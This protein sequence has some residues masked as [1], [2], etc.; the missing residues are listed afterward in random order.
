MFEE[1]LDSPE[2]ALKA[3]QNALGLNPSRLSLI[4]HVVEYC[5]KEGASEQL[6]AGLE[7]LVL[8]AESAEEEEGLTALV[9]NARAREFTSSDGVGDPTFE[10]GVQE[11]VWSDWRLLER[12]VDEGAEV[13]LI[14][15]SL[16][17]GLGAIEG[18]DEE[19][20]AAFLYL[21]DL[22]REL[23]RGEEASEWYERLER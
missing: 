7:L 22:R 8:Y 12:L 19:R 11:G 3:Y 17:F 20:Y 15:D 10:D 2:R 13:S 14:A 21:A 5:R 18:P 23:H 9:E 4:R 16:E 6:E 1:H